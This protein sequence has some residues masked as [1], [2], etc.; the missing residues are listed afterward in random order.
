MLRH[1]VRDPFNFQELITA[2][3]GF[4]RFAFCVFS[5][6]VETSLFAFKQKLY[7]VNHRGELHLNEACKCR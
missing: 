6:V 7:R 5:V 4:M 2:F 3:R 1:K